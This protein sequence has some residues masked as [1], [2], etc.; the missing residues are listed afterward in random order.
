MAQD[1]LRHFPLQGEM[2]CWHWPTPWPNQRGGRPCCHGARHPHKALWCQQLRSGS[3]LGSLVPDP[4]CLAAQLLRGL[5]FWRSLSQSLTPMAWTG[6]RGC[7]GIGTPIGHCG[8][9]R[10]NT[11]CS[12]PSG[13]SGA[14]H[15]SHESLSAAALVASATFVLHSA[16]Q[17]APALSLSEIPRLATAAPL[18]LTW[19]PLASAPLPVQ[20]ALTAPVYAVP[21]LGGMALFVSAPAREPQVSRDPLGAEGRKQPPLMGISSFSSPDEALAGTSVAPVLED[22]GVLQQLLWWVTQGLGIQAEEVVED[23]HPMVD[24]LAPSGPA[25]IALPLIKTVQQRLCDRPQPRCPRRLSTMKDAT[26]C[27]PGAAST[28]IRTLQQIPWSWTQ[29][30]STRATRDP[31]QGT[32]R[33]KDLFHWQFAALH[34]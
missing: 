4:L 14:F 16:P 13:R 20:S 25:H 6:V 32:G 28:F 34:F 15:Q 18:Q 7:N 33:R 19:T 9:H 11:R 24:L 21:S 27:H 22:N 2:N 31:P 1:L 8:H 29:P 12:G 23:A 26:L 30:M 3:L 10:G 17:E 5:H